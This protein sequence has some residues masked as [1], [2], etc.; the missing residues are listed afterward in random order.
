MTTISPDMLIAILQLPGVTLSDIDVLR[1][2][3]DH[4]QRGRVSPLEAQMILR[5][6]E[7][8]A[9]RKIPDVIIVPEDE[10]SW[11]D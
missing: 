9:E 2:G 7:L 8:L 3:L 10:A 4:I 11:G 6:I 5:I 1:T